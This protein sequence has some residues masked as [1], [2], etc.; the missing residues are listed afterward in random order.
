MFNLMGNAVKFTPD[1]G[2]VHVSALKVS[3][4][5]VIARDEVPK[6]SQDRLG[7]GSTISKGGATPSARNDREGA[8]IE[9]SVED[10]SIGIKP[11]DMSKL[12]KGSFPGSNRRMREEREREQGLE[13][14]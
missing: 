4:E 8:F 14:H 5:A 1:G 13:L 10:T 12:F 7:T 2:S 6:Q 3:K 9:I 11:E